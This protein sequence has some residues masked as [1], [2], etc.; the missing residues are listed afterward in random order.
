MLNGI[1]IFYLRGLI[2]GF[3]LKF[4]EGFDKTAEDRAV[5]GEE[6]WIYENG[7]IPNNLNYKKNPYLF[8]LFTAIK[9]TKQDEYPSSV[10]ITYFLAGVVMIAIVVSQR[11][12]YLGNKYM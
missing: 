10:L 1:R 3:S 4:F 11:L 12:H 2:K 7:N 6:W 8:I 5:Y 9:K